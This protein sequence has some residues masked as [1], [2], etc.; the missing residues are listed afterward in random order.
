MTQ[1]AVIR[2]FADV[3]V[4]VDFVRVRSRG[5]LLLGPIESL[6]AAVIAP[7]TS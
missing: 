5:Q 1:H 4:E 2:R 3:A 6:V 7:S